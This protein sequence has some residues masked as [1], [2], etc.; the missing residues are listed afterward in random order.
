[1]HYCIKTHQA[2]LTLNA[3][4]SQSSCWE[5]FLFSSP[6]HVIH[7]PHFAC[8]IAV[9]LCTFLHSIAA[10][11]PLPQA[12]IFGMAWPCSRLICL[13]QDH[14]VPAAFGPQWVIVLPLPVL[15][16]LI[17]STA[18]QSPRWGHLTTVL[19]E[20]YNLISSLTLV[21]LYSSDNLQMAQSKIPLL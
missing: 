10:V 2:K 9:L 13:S 16:L 20:F 8:V 7:W 1:M 17:G 18:S 15:L 4:I 14:L 12:C 21:H 5:I 3:S 19:P 11:L 6:S